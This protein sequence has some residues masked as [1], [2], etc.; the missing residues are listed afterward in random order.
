MLVHVRHIKHMHESE[1]TV[2]IRGR[3]EPSS[4][5]KHLDS[6]GTERSQPRDVRSVQ[7]QLSSGSSGGSGSSTGSSERSAAAA[8]TQQR[9]QRQIL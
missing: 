5:A 8:A 4:A 2:T 7:Q 3:L 1:L 6:R 9:R